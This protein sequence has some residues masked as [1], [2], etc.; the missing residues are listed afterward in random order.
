[1]FKALV[2]SAS[3]YAVQGKQFSKHHEL[4]SYSFDQYLQESGK[5]YSGDE[6]DLRLNIFNQNMEKI[7]AHNG[8]KRSWKMG[9]NK[10]TDMTPKEIS[11]S[12]GGDKYSLHGNKKVTTALLKDNKVAELPTHVDWRDV[13]PSVVSPVKDQGHC[14]SCWAFAATATIESHVAINTGLLNEVSQQELVSCMA[15]DDS[16]GGTG[17]CMGATAELA[18]DYLADK[19]LSELWSYGYL[20]NTY[21]NG[22]N[23]KC[24]RDDSSNVVA[25]GTGYTLLERNNY[26]EIMNAVANVGPMAV[27][28]DASV[29]HMYESGVFDGC[30]QED[31]DINHVVGLVGYGTCEVHGDFWIIRNSWSPSWGEGGYMKLKRDKSYCGMD[32]HNQDGVGCA[33]DPVNVTVCGQCGVMYDVS[34]PTGAGL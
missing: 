5:K 18:F 22:I 23:N 33:S 28:V 16:C 10:F 4:E 27:N 24:L 11:M 34:Y 1:M 29:W 2:L 25:S 17:G 8:E 6:Y 26:D 19:G 15:N 32:Y 9:V 21:M 14:G 13:Q 31:V 3:L 12:Y 20:P 30:A 7:K